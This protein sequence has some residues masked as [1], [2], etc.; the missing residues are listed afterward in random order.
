MKRIVLLLFV[1]AGIVFTGCQ[2]EEVIP[3]PQNSVAFAHPEI[4]LIGD[5]TT[6]SVAFADPAAYA[7]SIT[8][9]VTETGVAYG[10][11]FTTSPEPVNHSIT[12]PFEA[13][14]SSVSF[15]FTRLVKAYEGETKNVVFT[16]TGI[17]PQG[18]LIPDATRRVQVNF[19]ETPVLSGEIAP[20]VGGPNVP[21]QVFV[22]LSSG[23]ATAVARTSWDLG[24][25]GGDEF[26]V[27][28]NGATNMAAKQL[29]S[30]DLTQ[31]VTVDDTVAV[32]EDTGSGI[33]NGNPAYVDGPDGS[34]THTAIAEV[35]ANDGDNKVYLVNLGYKVSTILPNAGSVN[36]YGDAR[37]WIKIRVL[38]D[39]INYKLQYANVDS[40]TFQEVSIE[41]KAAFNFTFFSFN[42]NAVVNVEPEKAKWDLNFT[43]F[44]DVANLGSGL[45]SYAYQ[46]FI[47]TNTKSG[48][49]AYE[50]LNS[51]GISYEDF[52]LA[53]VASANFDLAASIDQRAIG[54]KWRNDGSASPDVK[55]DRFYIL[56]DG[57]GN[58]YKLRFTAI[59]NAAG[60]R[61]NPAFE[62]ELLR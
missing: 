51:A 33:Q 43:S 38:R 35:S 23:T 55:S 30:N 61:G 14:A 27:V 2:E 15:L 28:L 24:F 29:N 1:F 31:L 50:V 53:D 45:L 49:R 46:D 7:G 19:D 32:G 58:V 22:D 54:T 60:E 12:I 48:T 26:R 10:T 47:V 4:D 17:D 34:I 25:Y 41:K 13:G 52:T 3:D 18:I 9:S 20:E 8:F 5:N 62:Y 21:N 42:T 40:T 57:A 56:K 44:T 39:G 16:I 11:D 59:T 36:A 6:V 37:G